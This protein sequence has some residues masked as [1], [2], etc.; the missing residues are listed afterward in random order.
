MFALTASIWY[1]TRKFWTVNSY[2]KKKI[3][4]VRNKTVFMYMQYDHL[5]RKPDGICSIKKILKLIREFIKVTG[6][7][8]NM[9]VSGIFLYASNK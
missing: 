4:K 3:T 2:K 8:I 9:Q 6:Y 5:Y 1:C 7:R